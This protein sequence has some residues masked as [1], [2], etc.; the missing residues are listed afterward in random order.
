MAENPTKLATITKKEAVKRTLAKLGENAMPTAIQ[1]DLKEQF[2]IEITTDYA[3][4]L[5]AEIVGNGGAAKTP[6]VEAA[7]VLVPA[8]ITKKEAVK[9][10][11]AKLGKTAMPKAMQADIKQRFGLDM[12]LAHLSTTKSDLLREGGKKKKQ[13]VVTEPV[14]TSP[15]GQPA[16]PQSKNGKAPA[17]KID[18]ILTLQGLVR[19][20][21]AENLRRL[22]DVLSK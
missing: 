21:G 10:S 4:K 12:T 8:A 5:K 11:L 17:L 20:I 18:D 6:S 14:A 9:R 15:Q 3:G 1:A 22:I 19:R 13:P 2:G 7:P 16:V